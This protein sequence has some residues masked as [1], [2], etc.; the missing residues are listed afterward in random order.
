M[1]QLT[2]FPKA[3]VAPVKVPAKVHPDADIIGDEIL[4]SSAANVKVGRVSGGTD[5][6]FQS[7]SSR[8]WTMGGRVD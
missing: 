2:L 1:S 8:A 6:R 5:S 3:L 7:S 4:L